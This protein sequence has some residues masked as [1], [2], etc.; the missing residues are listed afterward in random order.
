MSDDNHSWD[1]RTYNK[2]SSNVQLEWGQR[3][4]ER[5][6]WLGNEIVMDGGAG[7]GNLTKILASKV[8][9]GQVYAVDADPNMVKQSITNLSDCR[10]VKILNSSMDSVTLPTD[11]DVVFLTQPCT[12]F[13]I[14]R[15]L[16]HTFGNY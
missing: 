5:R 3:L 14:W 11:V 9:G 15:R 6:K 2:I 13:Q 16:F 10:N 1:A 12:G 7:S 8:S 4:L